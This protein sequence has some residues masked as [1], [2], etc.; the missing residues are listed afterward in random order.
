[1]EHDTSTEFKGENRFIEPARVDWELRL[2]LIRF[3]LIL[4]EVEQL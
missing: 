4:W 2:G 3:G 1:M